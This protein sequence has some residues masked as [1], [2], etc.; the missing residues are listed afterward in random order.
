VGPRQR[1]R[2]LFKERQIR[3]P[4]RLK[5]NVSKKNPKEKDVDPSKRRSIQHVCAALMLK[6]R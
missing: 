5:K 3:K 6:K 4:K 1:E 2:G